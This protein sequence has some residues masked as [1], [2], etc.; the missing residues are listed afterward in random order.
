MMYVLYKREYSI[1]THSLPI[2]FFNRFNSIDSKKLA[3]YK[4]RLKNNYKTKE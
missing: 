4:L 1:L 2:Y 3:V